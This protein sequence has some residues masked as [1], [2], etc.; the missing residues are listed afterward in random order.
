MLL[1]LET[2]TFARV[3]G[4]VAGISVSFEIEVL[5]AAERRLALTARGP[6]TL[7]V[8]YEAYPSDAGS[9]EVWA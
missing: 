7:E 4:R 2:G 6:I 5:H 9:A 8:E 3:A 1:P